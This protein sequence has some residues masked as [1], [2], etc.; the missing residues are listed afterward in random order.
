MLIL[1][2]FVSVAG[3][4]IKNKDSSSSEIDTDHSNYEIFF[5]FKKLKNNNFEREKKNI[6]Y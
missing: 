2:Y 6:S 1:L 5:R 4:I 3:N